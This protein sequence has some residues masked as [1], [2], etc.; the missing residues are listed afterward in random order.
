[1]KYFKVLITYLTLFFKNNS[2]WSNIISSY[3]NAI[4]SFVYNSVI[5]FFLIPEQWGIISSVLVFKDLAL[6]FN[7]GEAEY[8]RKNFTKENSTDLI[9]TS[10]YISIITVFIYFF[11]FVLL[12][13]NNYWNVDK[14]IIIYLCLIF[15]CD[16][17]NYT[18]TNIAK[19]IGKF[20]LLKITYLLI[21]IL[22]LLTIPLIIFYSVQG[23]FLSKIISSG[24]SFIL[25]IFFLSKDRNVFSLG[26]SKKK[27]W[28]TIVKLSTLL[29]FTNIAIFFI[30][31]IPKFLV[32]KIHSSKELGYFAF[33]TMLMAPFN[34]YYLISNDFFYKKINVEVQIDE[35][36]ILED[37]KKFIDNILL[38]YVLYP[39][40]FMCINAF[41][42]K[43]YQREISFYFNI[44][45]AFFIQAMTLRILNILVVKSQKKELFVLVILLIFVV[46]CEFSLFM[47][48]YK[49]DY[50]SSFFYLI[51][52]I[53]L[54][55]VIFFFF[56]QVQSKF[57]NILIELLKAFIIAGL[58]YTV[59]IYI[60]NTLIKMMFFMI[61]SVTFF[62][63]KGRK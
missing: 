55:I 18:P 38:L 54:F 17:L 34:Q 57:N 41:F 27:S 23:F 1:M 48:W 37:L 22:N 13:Y 53:L 40:G 46:L 35:S 21:P 33:G 51:S 8:I 24:V 39:L 16:Y 62:F 5:L 49:I 29:Q 52:N 44:A 3:T 7:L 43:N 50:D 6:N 58:I 61:L 60:T 10:F 31:S 4:L 36:I 32:H 30:N 25:L 45:T 19:N 59:Q 2:L 14:S 15:I 56:F 20:N 42:F 47:N 12:F 11:V 9:K 63:R 26:Q 28:I